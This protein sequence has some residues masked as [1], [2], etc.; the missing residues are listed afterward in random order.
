MLKILITL[1]LISGTVHGQY[2]P[3]VGMTTKELK[4]WAAKNSVMLDSTD[5]NYRESDSVYVCGIR[6]ALTVTLSRRR[7]DMVDWTVRQTSETV[8]R[9]LIACLTALGYKCD[10]ADTQRYLITR[11]R[12]YGLVVYDGESISWFNAEPKKK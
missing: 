6:G 2:M 11:V 10:E 9:S 5:V 8:Y 12:K 7:V 1:L 3:S 4:N